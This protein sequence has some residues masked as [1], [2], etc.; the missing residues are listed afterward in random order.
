MPIVGAILGAIIYEL[1]VGIHANG[2][3]QHAVEESDVAQDSVLELT[4]KQEPPS[5]ISDDSIKV[6]S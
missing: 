6:I 4:F 3:G 1:V 2:A 5:Y